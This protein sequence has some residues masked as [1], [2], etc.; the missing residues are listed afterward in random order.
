[1]AQALVQAGARVVVTSRHREQAQA[2]AMELG[3]GARGVE[4]D[5]R[6]A[7][8]VAGAVDSA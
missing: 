2:T 5:V 8:S 4:L 7:G 6:D 3:A 1:M